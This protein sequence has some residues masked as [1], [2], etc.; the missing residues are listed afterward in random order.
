[1]K[2]LFIIITLLSIQIMSSQNYSRIDSTVATYP[3]KFKSIEQFANQIDH[4]FDTNIEKT[5]AAYF[6]IANHITYDYKTFRKNKKPQKIKSKSKADYEAKLQ[7]YNRKLAQKTLRKRSA[8][9]EGYSRLLTEV[10]KDLNIISVVVTGY[11]KTYVQEIGRKRN[12]SNHAWN[13]VKLDNKWYLIDATWSTGNSIYNSEFFNFSDTYFMIDPEK[14]VLTHFPDDEQWQLL[15]KPISKNDYFNF[16]I[17]YSAYHTSGL[18]LENT[19]SG[20]IITKTDS[21]IQL[22]FANI[23]KDKTYY[24]SFVNSGHSGK[25]EFIYQH[26]IYTTFIPYEDKRR[27][28][29]VISDGQLAL[30]KFKIKLISP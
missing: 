26:G 28:N 8:V 23:S 13:A 21:V 11:T 12:N 17:F 27:R 20:Y 19:T 18:K 30:M 7:I 10:L 14:L 16:P 3:K 5:R 1:M 22:D 29:L 9:C 24:Y 6:W 4:D 25:I 15:E 2:R